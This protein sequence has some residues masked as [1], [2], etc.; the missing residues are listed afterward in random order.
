[1]ARRFTAAALAAESLPE[2]Q[3]RASTVLRRLRT[4][5]EPRCALLHDDPLQLLVATILSAQ[6]T[7]EQVNK[8]TPALFARYPTAAAFAAAGQDELETAIGSIG[9]F[10]NKAKSIR[11]ACQLLCEEYGGVVPATMPDLLRLPGV[12]RKTANVVLGTAFGKAVGVVVD[13]H[14]QRLSN[15]LGLTAESDNTNR[16][17]QDLMTVL[18]RSRWIEAAH[19]LIWHGRK[20]CRAQRPNCAGCLVADLCPQVGVS[21]AG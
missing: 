21:P 11:G 7:D 14:V 5:Y 18:P 10:R 17:E 15:R 6:T 2:R 19:N 20:C 4:L 12:A 13:T 1:M 3:R 9:L 8:V 16:I